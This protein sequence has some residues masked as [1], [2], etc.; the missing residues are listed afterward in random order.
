MHDIFGLPAPSERNLADYHVKRMVLS[1][2]HW[3]HCNLPVQLNW[4]L[5]PFNEANVANV[6]DNSRGVYSFVVQPSIADHPACSYLL[7]VGQT[8]SQ[9]FRRRF[10]Q[11]L[12]DLRAGLNSRRPHVAEMLEKWDGYLWFGYASITPDSLIVTI[13]DALLESYL[14]PVNKDFPATV[15]VSIRRLF[16]N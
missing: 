16:G 5:L 10:R 8:E 4:T 6:P 1:P 3:R 14:P 9:N 13:E 15:S 2:D 12:G 11:Y 7:Y